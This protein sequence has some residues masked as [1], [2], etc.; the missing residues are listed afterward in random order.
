MTVTKMANP[1]GP[2]PLTVDTFEAL[3]GGGIPWGGGLGT[4][5]ADAHITPLKDH[6]FQGL[7]WSF[8]GNFKDWTQTMG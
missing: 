8:P 3:G 5:S 6:L 2:I 7:R 1:R 4:R